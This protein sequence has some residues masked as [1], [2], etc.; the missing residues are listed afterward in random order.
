MRMCL[1]VCVCI[2]INLY[3]LYFTVLKSGRFQLL[4]PRKCPGLYRDYFNTFY[5]L[6]IS[7]FVTLTVT[8]SNRYAVSVSVSHFD[9]YKNPG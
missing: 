1:C 7:S 4:D 9:P 3:D 2:Y 6:H 8:S 5:I